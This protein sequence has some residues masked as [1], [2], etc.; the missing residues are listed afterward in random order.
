MAS[1]ANVP[2]VLIINDA[3]ARLESSSEIAALGCHI[4]SRFEYMMGDK[5]R[6]M[7]VY[8]IAGA[9]LKLAHAV[10]ESHLKLDDLILVLL[11]ISRGP[12]N[13]IPDK[14][15]KSKLIKTINIYSM[16]I[17]YKLEFNISFKDQARITLSDLE[18]QNRSNML[19]LPSWMLER[20]DEDDDDTDSPF[21]DD[22][23]D[24]RDDLMT[25][26]SRELI[27]PH[28]YL[29]HYLNIIKLLIESNQEN[30]FY[31]LA[32]IAW[33]LLNDVYWSSMVLLCQSRKLACASLMLAIRICRKDLEQSGEPNKM[34][35]W[36]YIDKKWNLIFCDDF[37]N[38]QCDVLII[39]MVERFKEFDKLLEFDLEFDATTLIYNDRR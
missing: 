22:D 37:T 39:N 18:L 16:A 35:L 9:C 26:N 10:Y 24:Q 19:P 13:N 27:S 5:I 1:G 30:S 23:F 32:N 8:A 33:I 7:D 28:R 34:K 12:A 3:C 6:S 25:K 2:K 14:E 38:K 17:S 4:Y 21:S 36:Q 29:L 15:F 31:K 11:T 20:E